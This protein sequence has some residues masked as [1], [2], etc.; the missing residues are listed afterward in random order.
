MPRLDDAYPRGWSFDEHICPAMLTELMRRR[1]LIV[2]GKGGVGRTSVAAAMGLARARHGRRVLLME[3]DPQAAMS[4]LFGRPP[5]YDPVEVADG[6][7]L[8]ALDGRSAMSQYLSLVLPSARL[9]RAVLSSRLYDYF[10][11]AAPGLRELIMIGKLLHEIERRPATEKPWDNVIFDAPASGHA[12][13]LLSMPFAVDST[14]GTG[15]VK[16]ESRNIAA[17]LRDRDRT[18][19]I[20]VATPDSLT[21]SETIEAYQSLRERGLEPTTIVMNRV[22]TAPF[23]LAEV[24]RL[25]RRATGISKRQTVERLVRIAQAGLRR[26]ARHQEAINRIRIATGA[27]VIEIPENPEGEG[28]SLIEW[29][30]EQFGYLLAHDPNE[31]SSTTV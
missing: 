21:V 4:H 24:D 22:F 20:A 15:V 23:D 25:G 10:V 8:S 9:T 2:A 16:R 18:A 6:L 5:S 17:L 7:F 1:L 29:L 3:I 27:G 13:S 31:L 11:Q 14:F 26:A 19:I 12:L 28:F 30:A